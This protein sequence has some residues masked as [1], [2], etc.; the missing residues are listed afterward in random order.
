MSPFT[1]SRSNATVPTRPRA[2]RRFRFVLALGALVAAPFGSSCSG[3]QT[4]CRGYSETDR[5]YGV[6]AVE[7]AN[8]GTHYE[9][10]PPARLVDHSTVTPLPSCGTIAPVAG[11]TLMEIL[12][13]RVHGPTGASSAAGCYVDARLRWNGITLDQPRNNATFADSTLLT[14]AQGRVVL[15]DTCTIGVGIAVSDTGGGTVL[16]Y[17]PG[18]SFG[19]SPA[20]LSRLVQ[21]LPEECPELIPL[22]SSEPYFCSDVYHAYYVR[23]AADIDGGI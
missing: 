20:V 6:V 9:A 11:D 3:R 13:G 15:S 1:S 19:M 5:P 7:L 16:E 22:G 2:S 23:S 4:N 14:A 17:G 10:S 8:G 18:S 21:V 12:G